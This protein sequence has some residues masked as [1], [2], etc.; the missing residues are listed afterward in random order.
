MSRRTCFLSLIIAV[1]SLNMPQWVLAYYFGI[2]RP[3]WYMEWVV[4]VLLALLAPLVSYFLA[5]ILC[6]AEAYWFASSHFPGLSGFGL[7]GLLQAALDSRTLNIAYIAMPVVYYAIVI[8]ALWRLLGRRRLGHMVISVLIMTAGIGVQSASTSTANASF[9][10]FNLTTLVLRELSDGNLLR[11]DAKPRI[12][13]SD[14]ESA[15]GKV[16]DIGQ[17]KGIGLI[18][19]EALGYYHDRRLNDLLLKRLAEEAGVLVLRE[20][21]IQ[22]SSSTVNAELRELCSAVSHGYG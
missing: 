3:C 19:V 8:Y 18:I 14:A 1:L 2:S 16:D 15:I 17:Y 5:L 4:V 6:A 13:L 10:S 9:T 11:A 21:Y 22:G 20:G 7:I 12:V